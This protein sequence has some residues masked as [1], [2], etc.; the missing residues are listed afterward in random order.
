MNNQIENKVIIWG[1]DDFNTLGLLRQLNKPEIDLFF[2]VKGKRSYA[3][4]SKYCTN[5]YQTNSIEDGYNYLLER[6]SK[7]KKKPIIITSGDG[8]ITFIDKHREK[9]ESYFI[10][11]GTSQ[12][13]LIEKYIDKN[14]MTELANRHGFLCPKS[15]FVKWNTDISKIEYPCIIKPS[16]E[17]PG[18]YNEFKFKICY[19]ATELKR[20][21]NNVRHNSVFILQQ[22]IPKELDL[23][24]YGARLKNEEII[25]AGS[26]IRD[27]FADSGSSS[28][29]YLIDMIPQSAHING[30]H[31]F[32]NS[33]DY[34][35]PFSFEY[36]LIGDKA[37]FFE[38]N[39]RNDGTSHYFYQAGANIPLAYVYSC[40][41]KNY[42]NIS[43][44]IKSEKQYFV[45]EIF[46]IEN[47]FHRRISF[48]KFKEDKSQAIIYKYYD[49]EDTAPWEY[50]HKHRFKQ[51][52]QDIILKKYRIY[53][54]KIL[55]TIGLKK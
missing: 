12:K 31:S 55:E 19:N 44:K 45:D 24:V 30:I 22:Y 46:D 25:L 41:G 42:S 33:I 10:L 3:S 40:L 14:N 51:I 29:G 7:E 27:R 4:K 26:M 37:Y 34:Y 9:L 36:G 13:G 50:V 6:F 15:Q 48:Q 20:T 23:L 43:I 21:L 1:A 18:L 54:V 8:I 38:V 39:L 32:L 35:G 28:H 53:I 16:H 52:I 49:K 17:Q 11:P 5:S 47:V 2:L